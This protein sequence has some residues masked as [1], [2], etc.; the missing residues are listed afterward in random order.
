MF[1]NEELKSLM[2]TIKQL[3][4][5]ECKR[6]LTE[7]NN[8]IISYG[9]IDS[10]NV[11]GTFNVKIAGT[12]SIY[13]NIQNKCT[14]DELHIG[15]AVILKAINGNMGNGYIA[16]K[17]GTDIRN[18]GGG[19]DVESV[20]GQT[21]VVVL[22]DV[23]Y[24]LQTLTTTQKAQARTNIGAGTSNFSGNYSDLA[25]KP[26]IP[27][28]TSDLTNDSNFITSSGAPVQSVDGQT[29]SVTLND[30]KYTSQTLT[31]GQKN[32]A[33]NN[34][35]AGTSSFDGNYNNLSNKPSIPSKTSDLNN[36]SNFI[37]SSQAPVQSVNTKVGTVVLT[38]DDIGNGSTYVRTHNDFTD[39]LK[40]QITTNASG[41]S[42]L[43]T[44][45]NDLYNDVNL[46]TGEIDGK[47]DKSGGTMSGNIDMGGFTLNNLL[48]AVSDNQPVTYSQ[49][50]S[51][52]TGLGTVFDLKGSK[53]TYSDLPATGNEIG[54]VWYVEDESVGYIWIQDTAQILRWEQLGVAIDLSGYVA[55]AD[56]LQTTGGS[57]E[58]P[59]SQNA[60]T[61]L[62]NDLQSQI[63]GKLSTSGDGSNVTST[64]IASTILENITSG[65]KISV[66][67]GKISKAIS[68]LISH[69]ANISNPH[70][71]TKS[72][73]GLGNVD[74]VRQ[75]SES[76]IPPY[77]VTSVN[78]LTGAISL[79]DVKYTAQTLTDLQKAQARSNIGA[80][81]SSFSGNYND[82]L[83]KPIIPTKTSDLNNDSGFLTSIPIGGINIG[84]VKNGGNVT[85]NADGTMD[86]EG[87]GGEAETIKETHNN[88]SMSIW[89]GTLAEYNA[90]TTKDANTIYM[91]S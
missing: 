4:N 77:P 58:M 35:G 13:T 9:I 5:T 31:D 53:A 8:E 73:V 47:L 69:I 85:I 11:D 33:R 25:D 32:Q 12:D 90:L 56:L 76:N 50:N 15:D 87:G 42:T 34:I 57:T 84:G 45:Y 80:G 23:K 72:Q 74:N 6:I 37:T 51:A 64:F 20:N 78:G 55:K 89:Y 52:I 86:A 19:G 66:M 18:A 36:D 29:G 14:S 49:L 67:L 27:S 83:N 40:S 62:I 43:T 68:D 1:T 3:A 81:D 54:D 2:D 30:I 79:N 71:V 75:Y 22:N 28:K 63:N 21:G 41:I 48:A 7:R 60:I 24:T 39:A 91:C 10:A 65:S 38:Q 17:T 16:V 59:M 88:L 70:S 44:Q 61:L 82:L 26:T 46:L